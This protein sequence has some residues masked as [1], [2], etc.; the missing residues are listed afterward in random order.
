VQAEYNDPLLLIGDPETV[1]T[2]GRPIAAYNK[3]VNEK[4]K[5][6]NKKKKERQMACRAAAAAAPH[7]ATTQRD[8]SQ[9][10][11][12]LGEGLG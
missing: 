12:G 9:W 4:L 3:T 10:E 11:I 8:P 6:F 7:E 1:Q 2:K 5:P